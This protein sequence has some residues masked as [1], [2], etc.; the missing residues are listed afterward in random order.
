[1]EFIAEILS[2][3]V[4]GTATPDDLASARIFIQ[5]MRTGILVTEH[6][7]VY[8]VLE[9]SANGSTDGEISWELYTGEEYDKS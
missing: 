5:D 8:P 1:M 7:K 2:R 6:G 9:S 4:D 3:C